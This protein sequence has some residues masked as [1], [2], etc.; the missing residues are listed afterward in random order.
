MCIW[1]P[2][3]LA[4]FVIASAS[5][6]PVLSLQFA[7]AALSSSDRVAS[8]IEVTLGNFVSPNKYLLM[9]STLALEDFG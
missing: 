9:P 4:A 7:N 6:C 8:K 5:F 1:D 3:L 2:L